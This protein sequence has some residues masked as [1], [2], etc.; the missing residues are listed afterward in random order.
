[1]D[2]RLSDRQIDEMRGQSFGP[3]DAADHAFF[4]FGNFWAIK[5][6]FSANLFH[7]SETDINMAAAH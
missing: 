7:S 4:A 2:G 6:F 1:M 5:S 3:S